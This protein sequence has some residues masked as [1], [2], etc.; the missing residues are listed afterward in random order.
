MTTDISIKRSRPGGSLPSASRRL[1]RH[2]LLIALGIVMIYPLLWMIASS[3]RSTDVIFHE[4]GIWLNEFQFGNYAKG[5][6]GLDETFGHYL[7]NSTIIAL[8]AVIGNVLSCAVTAY[9]FARLRFRGKRLLFAIMLMTIMLPI[10]V[11]IVPQYIIFSSLG[12]VNTF[13]PLIVPKFL[14]TDAFFVFLMVQFIRGIPRELDEAARIDGCGHI[15]VFIRVILPLMGPVLATTAIFT[16]IWNWND[17]FSQ[18][19]YLTSPSTYSVPVALRSFMD[20]TGATAWGPLFA[21]SVVSLIPVFIVFLA[22]QRL[23]VR[24]IATTGGK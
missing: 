7:V 5:W 4:I 18:L 9:V 3:L 2:A 16:F 6:N 14:A 11:V 24:G 21:M 13:L 12:W 15:R 23:L 8:F 20:A 1:L 19:I 17:F 10:H 22:G